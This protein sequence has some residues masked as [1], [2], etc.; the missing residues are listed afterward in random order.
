MALG[1]IVA[2]C[3][4]MSAVVTLGV[5]VAARH[6]AAAAA[7]LAALAAVDSPQGCS[8]AGSVAEIN[9][10]RLEECT[11]QG[12]GTVLVT[13]MVEVPGLAADVR[14]RARA[15]PGP[16]PIPTT[17]SWTSVRTTR[18]TGTSQ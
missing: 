2:T 17:T 3:L 1:L 8:A 5:A 6:R 15:G 11:P 13:V 4:L 12:N 14:G 10:A 9:G 16:A 7:D 18:G